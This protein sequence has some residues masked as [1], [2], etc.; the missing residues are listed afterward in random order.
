MII[1]IW[2]KIRHRTR[3]W[4]YCYFSSIFIFALLYTAPFSQF[5]HSTLYL[6]EEADSIK[7]SIDEKIEETIN[8]NVSMALSDD[9]EFLFEIWWSSGNKSN[10]DYKFLYRE[11]K[12]DPENQQLEQG[13]IECS[14][15]LRVLQFGDYRFHQ[16]TCF[17]SSIE[18]II[19]NLP[20][21]GLRQT[22]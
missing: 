4:V 14:I 22:I 13:S 10:I 2:K 12:S 20:V 18:D 11:D 1:T 21:G 6:E 9:K 3:L 15:P 5:Y 17:R 7:R 19:R 16:L 8:R